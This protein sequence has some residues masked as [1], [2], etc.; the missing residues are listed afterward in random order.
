MRSR[1]RSVSPTMSVMK[2][3]LLL[4]V[5]LLAGTLA[6]S[7]FAATRTVDITRTGFVPDRLTIDAGD[8]VTWTNKDTTQHQV[9]ADGGA[10]PSSAVL[11]PSQSYSYRFA[12]SGNFSYRD[13]VNRNERGRIT[14]REGVTLATGTRVVRF[15]ASATLSGTVSNGQAGENVTVH[16]QACGGATS[17]RLGSAT[18]VANGAWSLAVKPTLNTVYEAR[19]RNTTSSKV[20]VKV[21]PRTALVKLRARRFSARVTAASSFAGKYVVLQRYAT[22]RRR[23]VTVK[24]VVLRT[25]GAPVA[26]AITTRAG[27]ASRLR[28]GTRLRLVLPQSQ[29]GTCHAAA[30]SGM[31][32]A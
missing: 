15:G 18:S 17:T 12:R 11:Q 26:G 5:A 31:V 2:T 13:G 4:A 10:F 25:A 16:A 1:N 28:R 22:A 19:W 24:R 8:T 23:W 21:A 7:A 9:V 27:F 6:P 20:E 30:Q 14:V 3:T 29:A 32:R